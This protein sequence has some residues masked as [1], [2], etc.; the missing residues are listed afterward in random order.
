MTEAGNAIVESRKREDGGRQEVIGN[1]RV[2]EA[3]SRATLAL[4]TAMNRMGQELVQEKAKSELNGFL[5]SK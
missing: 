1:A 3:F 4:K 5:T 2:A